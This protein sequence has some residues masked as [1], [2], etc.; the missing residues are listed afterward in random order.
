MM[1]QFS[2]SMILT[3]S[4]LFC[5]FIL[6]HALTSSM[7]VEDILNLLSLRGVNTQGKTIATEENIPVSSMH[8]I[9]VSSIIMI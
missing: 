4:N 1:I 9:Q 5:L 2:C 3:R 7:T 6:T 8:I